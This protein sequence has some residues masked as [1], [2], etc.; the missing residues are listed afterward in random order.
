M[1]AQDYDRQM[2]ERLREEADDSGHCQEFRNQCRTEA[3][4]LEGELQ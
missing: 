4:K 3:D 2:I 1:N